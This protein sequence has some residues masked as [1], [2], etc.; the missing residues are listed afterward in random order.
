M[1]FTPGT[2]QFAGAL[3]ALQQVVGILGIT[4]STKS[5]AGFREHLRYLITRMRSRGA[6]AWPIVHGQ[7][8]ANV[9]RRRHDGAHGLHGATRMLRVPLNGQ[10]VPEPLSAQVL[11]DHDLSGGRPRLLGSCRRADGLQDPAQQDGAPLD[12]DADGRG[13]GLDAEG[14]DGGVGTHDIVGEPQAHAA[15]QR[16]GRAAPIR[17]SRAGGRRRAGQRIDIFTFEHVTPG[18]SA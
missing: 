13:L 16:G 18:D 10:T 1:P 17:G 9:C 6:R 14:R 7:R 5:G 12:V 3:P 11:A 2:H 15:G 8:R 4:N